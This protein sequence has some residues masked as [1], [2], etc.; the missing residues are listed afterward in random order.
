MK[1]YFIAIL[2]VSIWQSPLLAQSEK[3]RILTLNVWDGGDFFGL[4]TDE[5]MEKIC[6][7]F[8]MAFEDER[9]GWDVILLQEL[10]PVQVRK[11]QFRDCGYPYYSSV[12]REYDEIDSVAGRYLHTF[13]G[14]KA[15]TGLR[16]IARYPLYGVKRHTY[17]KNGDHL[18]IFK[19]GEYAVRK[20]AM[21]VEMEHPIFGT[22]AIANTHLVSTHPHRSYNMQRKRQVEEL[23]DFVRRE[24]DEDQFII[25]GGDFNFGPVETGQESYYNTVYN[26]DLVPEFSSYYNATYTWDDLMPKLFPYLYHATLSLDG[27]S[28]WPSKNNLTVEHDNEKIDHI[29]ASHNFSLISTAIC[30]G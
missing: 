7:R 4:Y 3:L 1:K 12:D 17:S 16:I 23:A 28:Y 18:L 2:F 27:Y 26:D 6:E 19:D 30:H 10:W 13:Y 8:K 22:V 20:S 25:V 9:E 11:Y 14:D 24:T 29:L 5:R 15:D 21:L